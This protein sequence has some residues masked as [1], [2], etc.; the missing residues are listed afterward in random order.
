MNYSDIRTVALKELV[1]IF[2]DKLY[3]AFLLI[4]AIASYPSMLLGGVEIYNFH[5]K[6]E[7]AHVTQIMLAGKS[8]LFSDALEN[9]K[10]FALNDPATYNSTPHRKNNLDILIEVPK[11]FDQSVAENKQPAVVVV[12]NEMKDF[13]VDKSRVEE[14]IDHLQQSIRQAGLKKYAVSDAAGNELKFDLVNIATSQQ[15]SDEFLAWTFPMTLIAIVAIATLSPALDLI[16]AERERFS[17]EPLLLAAVARKDLIIGKLCALIAIGTLACLLT[18]ISTV[19]IIDLLPESMRDFAGSFILTVSPLKCALCLPVL[20]PV[21][22]LFAA[23]SLTMSAYAR[24]FQQGIAYATPYILTA[25][26]LSG[27]ALVPLKHLPFA[28]Y[29]LP[30]ANA[31]VCIRAFFTHEFNLAGF[32]TTLVTSAACAW[33]MLRLSINLLSREETLFFVQTAP[34]HRKDFG[35]PIAALFVVAFLLMFYVG[36]LSTIINL[37]WGIL[38][39]QVCVVLL[40][41]LGLLR[42]LRQPIRETLS[43]NKAPLRMLIGAP[44]MAPGLVLLGG[45]LEYLQSFIL[46]MPDVFEKMFTDMIIPKDQPVWLTL[47]AVGVAPGICEETMFRGVILGLLRKKWP[48]MLSCVIVAVL[49]GLFHM[50]SYR[51]VPTALLGFILGVLVVRSKSIFPSMLL[52]AFNNGISVLIVALS[53]KVETSPG[54]IVAAVISTLIGSWLVFAP[55]KQGGST[56]N[57]PAGD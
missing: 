16:T 36:Q 26:L 9:N 47:L 56:T 33:L 32:V 27:T 45:G 25:F 21:I 17:L 11:D 10:T 55:D 35:Y 6:S 19:C 7:A 34:K 57:T 3:V 49:F 22:I 39:I 12:Y 13:F 31:A 53:L 30:V 37:F 15:R 40:P 29:L 23:S 20:A 1:D 8:Q 4:G 51:L 38:V 24:N 28:I 43:W 14:L 50:S 42:W 41:S 54:L 18:I 52:H 2:R 44:L 48:A 46:P 5:Q